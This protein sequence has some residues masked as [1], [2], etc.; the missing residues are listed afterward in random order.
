[1]KEGN[2]FKDK[3]FKANRPVLFIIISCSDGKELHLSFYGDTYNIFNR[4][5][6]AK[7]KLIERQKHFLPTHR[8]CVYNHAFAQIRRKRMYKFRKNIRGKLR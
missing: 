7:I 3:C 8:S 4:Q 6:F 5:F 1:M 2:C